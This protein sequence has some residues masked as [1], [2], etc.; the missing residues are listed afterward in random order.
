MSEYSSWTY[1]VGIH[2]CPECHCNAPFYRWCTSDTGD[3]EHIYC[4]GANGNDCKYEVSPDV[5]DAVKRGELPKPDNYGPGAPSQQIDPFG[6]HAALN[7]NGRSH[8]Y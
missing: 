3:S 2:Y 4:R 5:A 8:S 1:G 7:R 6:I